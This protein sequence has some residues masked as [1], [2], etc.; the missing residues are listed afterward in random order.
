MA[1]EK[2]QENKFPL[3]RALMAWL[4]SQ[5]DMTEDEYIRYLINRRI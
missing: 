3:G 5:R 2:E 4:A 1:E